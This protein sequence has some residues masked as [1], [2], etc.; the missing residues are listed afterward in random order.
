MGKHAKWSEKDKL[1]RLKNPEPDGYETRK[2]TFADASSKASNFL[3]NSGTSS[4]VNG[5]T[6]STEHSIPAASKAAMRA[7]FSDMC[8]H[9]LFPA[10]STQGRSNTRPPCFPTSVTHF[11]EMA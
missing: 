10:Y 1:T 6:F 7:L 11:A 2:S 3:R 9:L 5:M 8:S 4:F